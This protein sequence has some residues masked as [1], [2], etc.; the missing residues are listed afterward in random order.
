LINPVLLLILSATTIF[1]PLLIRKRVVFP[2]V[3]GIVFTAGLFVSKEVLTL[4]YWLY[5]YGWQIRIDAL[6]YFF[7]VLLT[8][9]VFMVA[10]YS[11]SYIDKSDNAYFG[12]L[13][14]FLTASM[15]VIVSGDFLNFFIFW[16]LVAFALYSLIKKNQPEVAHRYFIIQFS[17][18]SVLL[19]GIL[20]YYSNTGHLL[21]GPV[22]GNLRFLFIL[23]LGVKGA[24]WGLHFWLPEAHTKAPSSVSCLLSGFVVKLGIYGFIRLIP[25]YNLFF[26]VLGGLMALYGVVFALFQHD[27][28][29]LLAYHTISQLGYI[30]MGLGSGNIIGQTGALYHLFNHAVFK[31]LLFLAVGAAGYRLGTRDLIKMGYLYKS[32]PV[33]TMTCLVAALSIAGIAPFN[34]YI[35]KTLIKEGLY[36]INLMKHLITIVNYGTILSFSK[37]MYYGF[38]NKPEELKEKNNA[39]KEVPAG[40]TTAMIIMASVC[41]VTGLMPQLLL[42]DII[43]ADISISFWSFEKLSS[44]IYTLILGLVI[45]YIGRNILRPKHKVINDIDYFYR[46]IVPFLSRFEIKIKSI[47]TGNLSHYLIWYVTFLVVIILSIL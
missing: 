46:S 18:A 3:F 1:L 12:W 6:S 17:G 8:F 27:A 14:V 21:V 31:G 34:G 42:N 30:I 45:F 23:G 28:K 44:N 11:Y 20:L 43:F 4:P 39:L 47:H 15:G 19:L 32:M 25:D 40:M 5:P 33:T 2:F 7:L 24:I 35:S 37:L 10:L 29:T 36:D 13:G 38:F 41:L 22:P 16:E 9:L 26:L